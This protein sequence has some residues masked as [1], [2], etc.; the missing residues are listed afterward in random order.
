MK[1]VGAI[2]GKIKIL[3]FLCKLPLILRVDRK[4][5]KQAW[6]IYKGIPDIDCERDWSV[7]LGATLGDG[8]KIKKYFP[9]KAPVLI[10]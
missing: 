3:N 2:F 5:K 1:I 10:S 8:Q 6:D 4:R 7:S 9:G